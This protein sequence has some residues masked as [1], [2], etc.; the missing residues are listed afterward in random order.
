MTNRPARNGRALLLSPVV[1]DPKGNGLARRA[2]RW[3]AELAADHA[4]DILVVSS[5]PQSLPDRPLLGRM[6]VVPCKGPP[7]QS[8]KLADWI[9]PDARVVEAVSS[10]SGPVPDRIV[11]FRLYLHD[12]A[13]LLPQAWQARMEL[14]CDDWEAAT[15]FSLAGL[16]LRHGR[17]SAAWRRLIEA[18]RYARV[19]RE[20]FG[21]YKTVHVSAAEDIAGL[22]RLTGH[23]AL[24]VCPN[25]IAPEPDLA[26][27]PPAA[28]SKTL[29]FVGTLAY[30]PNEDAMLWFGAAI[31]PR[32]RRLVPQVRIVAAGRADAR[33]QRRMA[34][35]GIEYVHAPAELRQIYADCAVVIAPL[36]GGGGTKV[37][38]LEAWL[39]ARPLVVTSHAAR[40][41]E[42]HAGQHFLV[43]D[44]ARD[45][46]QACARLLTDPSLAARLARQGNELVRSNYLISDPE[47]TDWE[48]GLVS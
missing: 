2:W 31:L 18:A 1:P 11:V 28:G 19:E 3:A 43:A 27:C 29:L 35:D 15:R 30:P 37:K 26:L 9:D 10:L 8:R 41:F 12:V 32:L 5:Y 45:F 23:R 46:A 16:A 44:S 40:G 14:D 17:I 13:M 24:N 34:R 42:A 4:L 21:A 38:V 48:N 7:I 47:N 25:L 33:L 20:V 39:H 6:Q 36:R 22:R